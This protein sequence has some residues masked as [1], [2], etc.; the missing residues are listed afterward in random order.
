MGGLE[1]YL[2]SIGATW[3]GFLTLWLLSGLLKDAGIVDVW[4]GLGFAFLAW[5]VLLLTGGDTVHHWVIVGLTSLWGLRLGGYLFYRNVL[6]HDGEDRRYAAMRKKRPETFFWWSLVWVFS[7]QALILYIVALPLTAGQIAALDNEGGLRLIQWIGI[8]L[9]A[10]GLIF[11]TVGDWQLT[12][13]KADPANA[14]KVLDTGLWAWTRHPNYFG[15]AVVWWG[16]FLVAVGAAEP[17]WPGIWWTVIG[18]VLMTFFLMNVSGVPLLER[19]MKKTRPDYADYVARTS[20]FFPW[21][22][23]RRRDDP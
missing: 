2:W 19:G 8:V 11:E 20:A 18:P 6:V 7:L 16:L 9:F 10:V 15:D 13:F 22:P 1:V 23:K 5:A 17:L 4:W 21:P 12:A 14:G 3:C